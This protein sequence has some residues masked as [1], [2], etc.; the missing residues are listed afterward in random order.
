MKN[1]DELFKKYPRIFKLMEDPYYRVSS[2]VPNTWLQTLDWMCGAIEG[3]IDNINIHNK[4]L[5]PITQLVCEQIKE[6]FGELRFYYSGGDKVCDGI[7]QL[8]EYILW[9]T[10]ESCGSHEDLITTKNWISRKCKKCLE[11]EKGN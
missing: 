2:E 10:C 1:L 4:H 7:V 3:H 6:K 5:E 8:A 11:N 9:E